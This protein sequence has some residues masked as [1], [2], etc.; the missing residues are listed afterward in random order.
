MQTAV[1]HQLNRSYWDH[2]A[3][4]DDWRGEAW[5]LVWCTPS[6]FPYGEAMARRMPQAQ[7]GTHLQPLP[8]G[9]SHKVWAKHSNQHT[10]HC[11][12]KY[13][14]GTQSCSPSSTWE[15]STKHLAQVRPQQ[16]ELPTTMQTPGQNQTIRSQTTGT[17][18]QKL[19]GCKIHWGDKDINTL[20]K[21]EKVLQGGRE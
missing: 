13:H 9:P 6:A 17:Y 14:T 15:R 16:E 20:T 19:K 10:L 2:A 5:I 21:H 3:V 1:D 8:A 4:W 12:L 18:K 11:C 7:E